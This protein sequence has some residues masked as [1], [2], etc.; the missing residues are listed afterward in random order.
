MNQF[1]PQKILV[2]LPEQLE[3]SQQSLKEF[4]FMNGG[5][6]IGFYKN[7]GNIIIENIYNKS[8]NPFV[9]PC[10]F[11]CYNI[12]SSFLISINLKNQLQILNVY[13]TETQIFEEEK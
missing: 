7:T 8:I 9:N 3:K 5:Y 1:F 2:Q 10:E 6:L 11:V 12:F 13:T 4:I